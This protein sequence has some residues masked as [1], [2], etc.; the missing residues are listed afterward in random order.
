MRALAGV[1]LAA[2]VC[3]AEAANAETNYA[4]FPRAIEGVGTMFSTGAHVLRF[5]DSSVYDCVAQITN[6]AFA[7]KCN[8]QQFG[9]SMMHGDAVTTIFSPAGYSLSAPAGSGFWQLD[10]ATGEIQFCL[11]TPAD[12]SL[13]SYCATTT[14]R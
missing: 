13:I 2:I 11:L 14:I 1:L 3:S 12:V 4:I 5:R 8:K 10:Q 7:L 9:G 6:G